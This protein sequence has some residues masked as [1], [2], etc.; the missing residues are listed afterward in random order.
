MNLKPQERI[1]EYLMF[2]VATC[3]APPPR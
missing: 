3:V 1:L 2:S